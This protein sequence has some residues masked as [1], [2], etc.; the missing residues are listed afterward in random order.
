MEPEADL[1]LEKDHMENIRCV[2]S[3]VDGKE[4]KDIV[5]LDQS[6]QAAEELQACLGQ[7][8][9]VANGRS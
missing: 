8:E 7:R 1:V 4:T 3:E 9:V 2:P 5:L 6:V